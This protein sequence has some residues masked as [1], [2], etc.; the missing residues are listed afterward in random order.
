MEKCVCETLRAAVGVLAAALAVAFLPA[1][2]R[3]ADE[4]AAEPAAEATVKSG[5]DSAAEKV[6]ETSAEEPET[7]PAA[8]PALVNV[9]GLDWYTNYYE[10]NRDAAAQ[11]RYLLINITPTTAS[12]TQQSAEQYIAGNERVRQQMAHLIRL[13]VPQDAT[14]DVEGQ[15]RRLLSYG[16]FS[17]LQGGAGFVLIDLRNNGEPYYGYAVSVLPYA[18]GKFYHWRPD[19]LSTVLSIPAGSLTQ[20]TMIWA[21]RIHPEGPQSTFGTFHPAL[22]DGATHQASYQADVGEQG[23]QNFG[24]RFQTLSAAAGSSVSEVCAESWPGQNMIDSC[25]DCVDSWRHSSGHWRGVSGRHRAFGYDIRRGRNGI[26]Y[27]TGIFAD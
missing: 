21:V 4:V 5:A 15:T 2:V 9:A 24:S 19:Y 10:A 26:W 12:A 8:P 18:S 13:R 25:L 14:I 23:H 3:A 6:A 11:K 22:A 17:E 7:P 16:T 27:G 20:R 1:G